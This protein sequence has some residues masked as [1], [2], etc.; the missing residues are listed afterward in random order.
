MK[1]VI[2]IIAATALAVGSVWTYSVFGEDVNLSYDFENGNLPGWYALYGNA[3]QTIEEE[4]NGNKYLKISYNGEENRGRDYYDVKVKDIYLSGIVQIDYDIMYTENETEKNGDMQVKH[5]TGPGKS[6][7][8][9]IARV[10]KNMKY[11]RLNE[12][13]GMYGPVRDLNGEVLEI[14][15]GH[16]YSMKFILDLKQDRQ[17]LYVF[18]RDSGEILS[19]GSWK[20]TI[21][22]DI[23][24][25]MITFS[26][27]TDMCLDNV[28]I[29][30][31]SCDSG[32]ILGAPYL[33]SGTQT[34][35]YYMGTTEYG[36]ITA[37]K[38]IPVT[39][40]L[41]MPISGVTVDSETGTVTVS[42]NPEP[43]PVV[44]MSE[45]AAEDEIITTRH[46]IYISK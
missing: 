28:R 43:G 38:D 29:Y 4:E 15:P 17:I 34:K 5:R 33:S 30:K 9:F 37:P 35:Y 10:G 3:D 16:W 26:S 44:L 2:A 31:T 45:Q 27:G 22:P 39:W 46:L 42:D 40:S 24:P 12:Q 20:N 23:T 21:T 8:T 19:Y 18:D 11:F 1:K 6:E 7:T 32:R 25:N 14:V 41:E 13:N 36:D